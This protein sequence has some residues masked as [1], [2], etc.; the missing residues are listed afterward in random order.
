VR[1]QRIAAVEG[2]RSEPQMLAFSEFQRH[3]NPYPR[4]DI[5][6]VSTPEE[7]IEDLK[8][9]TLDDV[10]KFYAQFYGASVG[11]FSVAG[12]FDAAEAKKLA[13]ELF[14]SWKSPGPYR[15]ITNPYR[16]LEPADRKIETPD[17]QNAMFVAGEL[18]KMSDEDADFAAMELANYMLGG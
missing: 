1:Q 13:A 11:E 9:V 18:I 14:G 10:R 8:K 3:M 6:Y 12:Q 16:K 2:G 4:G 7:Q 15:R 17:K 5:R